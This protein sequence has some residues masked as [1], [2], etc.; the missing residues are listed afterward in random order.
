MGKFAERIVTTMDSRD[1]QTLPAVLGLHIGHDATASLVVDGE[2]VAAIGEER[3]SRTKQ[4]YGFPFEAIGKVLQIAGLE[5][6]Q[7]DIIA[8]GGGDPLEFNPWQARHIH[9]AEEKGRVDFS[10]AVPTRIGREA[11]FGALRIGL[12][13]VLGLADHRPQIARQ[14]LDRSLQQCGLDPAAVQVFDHH[15]CHAV[16]AYSTSP[17]EN[18]LSVTIDGYGDGIN[19]GIWSCAPTDIRR[20]AFGPGPEDAGAY[21]PGD[22]YSYITC[23][24]GFKRNRHEGKITG[25]ASY[26]DP[27][28]LFDKIQDLLQVDAETAHFSSS[29]SAFRYTAERRPHVI[30]RRLARWALTGELWDPMLVDELRRRCKGSSPAQVAAAAQL[31]LEERIVRLISHWVQDTGLSQVTL[32]GGV[33]ANVKLNQ[34]IAEIDG[35]EDIFVHPCMG[36]GGLSLGAALW[37]SRPPVA[38]KLSVIH[39]QLDDVFLGPEYSIDEMRRALEDAGVSYT[40]HET[41]ERRMAKA[42]HDG[43]VVARFDGR[44]EYGPRALGNR[45]IMARPTDTNIN[46]WLNKRLQRTEFMPFAPAVLEEFVAEIFP[47][48]KAGK[49]LRFMTVTLDVEPAWQKRVPAVCHIDGTARP[50]VLDPT[51]TPSFYKVVQFYHELSGLPL[52]INTSFNMHEEPIV[53]SPEDAV[54]AFQLGHL[55][56]L[57]IGPFWTEQSSE[58]P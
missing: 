3:L 54:R 11:C 37:G 2:I 53:C 44:M 23:Y 15:L 48:V 40:E 50:Q 25:L 19:T 22:F 10:N 27:Q 30:L 38:D 33:F 47:D 14:A 55:D 28:D 57:A 29:T 51:S 21:S 52:V 36:D 43:K 31:L 8:L 39:P 49:T 7:V 45:T 1:T 46:D 41:I 32:A 9:N 12:N 26:A 35:V 4:H 20:L 18:A 34:R 13:K 24:L 5:P 16:S 17:F 6:Q 58:A 42:I 56:A